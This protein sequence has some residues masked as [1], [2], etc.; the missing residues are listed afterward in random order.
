MLRSE[1]LNSETL[2]EII[3]LFGRKDFLSC[4]C[5]QTELGYTTERMRTQHLTEC[6]D[7]INWKETQIIH[8]DFVMETPDGIDATIINVKL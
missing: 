1:L 8:L 6:F 2:Q 7:W 3:D 4:K 5:M